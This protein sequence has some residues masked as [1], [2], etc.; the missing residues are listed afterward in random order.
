MPR[1]N[2]TNGPRTCTTERSKMCTVWEDFLRTIDYTVRSS[3]SG[4]HN[5]KFNLRTLY[6]GLGDVAAMILEKNSPLTQPLF[7]YSPPMKSISAFHDTISNLVQDHSEQF[8]GSSNLIELKD[9]VSFILTPPVAALLIA[10]DRDIPVADAHDV[11]D[12]SNSSG[13][14]MQPEGGDEAGML[15]DLHRN[16]AGPVN[17]KST[18]TVVSGFRDSN[19]PFSPMPSSEIETKGEAHLANF[20]EPKT[21]KKNPAKKPRPN[22]E[23]K[24]NTVSSSY[25]TRSKSKIK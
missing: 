18:A 11:R 7:V 17:K 6:M 24:P 20:A 15:D 16:I 14:L 23:A 2:K 9:F 8:D 1:R 10:R 12:N 4:T 19:A 3:L 22:A 25:G 5:P 21:Q 13:D